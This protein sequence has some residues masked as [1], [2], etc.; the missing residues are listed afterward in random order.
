[1]RIIAGRG[2][3]GKSTIIYDEI[4]NYIKANPLSTCILIVPD[5]ITFQAEN[6]MIARINNDGIMD[7]SILSIGGLVNKI[8]E[9]Q[10]KVNISE[11]TTFGKLLLLKKIIKNNEHRLNFYNK[12]IDTQGMLYELESVIKEFKKNEISPE[13]LKEIVLNTDRVVTGKKL[14]DIQLIYDDYI[15]ATRDIYYDSEDKL[16]YATK[17]I[18]DSKWIKNSKV[19]ID[20]YDHFDR[21]EISLIVALNQVSRG[22]SLSLNIDPTYLSN[23]EDKEDWEAFKIIH[24]TYHSFSNIMNEDEAIIE[25]SYTKGIADEVRRIEENIYSVEP[26][27]FEDEVK[28]VRVYGSLNPYEEVERAAGIIKRLVR[29]KGYRYKDFKL[30]VSD[31][32]LYSNEFKKIFDMEDIPYYIDENKDVL[33][34]ST[35][36]LIVSI[37]DMFSGNFRSEDVVKYL[38]SGYSKLNP[39]QIN[40]LE[41]AALQ[42]GLKGDGWFENIGFNVEEDILEAH[43]IFKSYFSNEREEYKRLS[44]IGDY[45]IFILKFL[46]NLQVK[47]QIK[48]KYDEYIMG[49]NYVK[50]SELSQSWNSIMEVLEQ[51]LIISEEERITI[52]SYK[53]LLETGLKEIKIRTIPPIIDSIEVGD[54]RNISVK[55]TKVLI[56]IG[57]TQEVVSDN[58]EKGLLTDDDRKVIINWGYSLQNGT[59]FNTFRSNHI[60]YRLFNVPSEELYISYPL[61]SNDNSTNQPALILNNLR[62]IYP[63]AFDDRILNDDLHLVEGVSRS[64]EHL[65]IFLRNYIE[66]EDISP[67][68]KEVYRWFSKNEVDLTSDLIESLEYSNNG[69]RLDSE[70]ILNRFEHNL[71]MTVTKLEKYSECP[72]KY[73]VEDI[74]RPKERIIQKVEFYDIGN[75]HHDVIEDYINSI[76]KDEDL[77]IKLTRDDARAL[78]K[79][80]IE[81]IRKMENLRNLAF[82]STKRN[83][84]IQRKMERVLLSSSE[85]IL[86]QIQSGEFRPRFSELNIGMGKGDKIKLDPY[87]ITLDKGTI[88]LRGKIDRVDTYKDEVG[89]EY[90]RIV[91]YKSSKKRI[92]LKDLYEGLQLQLFVYL[93]AMVDRGAS[94]LGSK[95]KVGG[96]YYFAVDDPI[97][98]QEVGDPYEAKLKELR[99]SGY[100]LNDSRIIKAMDLDYENSN[101][102][103]VR[104]TKAGLPYSGS[105][106]LDEEQFGILLDFVQDKV[107][108]ISSGI[109]NGDFPILPYKKNRN[110]DAC[111]YCDYK[112]ICMFDTTN[113]DMYRNIKGVTNKPAEFIHLIKSKGGSSDNGMD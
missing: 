59:E 45:S 22:L 97:F 24:D 57:L 8:L 37:L 60:L 40:K 86:F 56:I 32:R 27:T 74:L 25:S 58:K 108:E 46:T 41:N 83:K 65:A 55:G 7:V 67:S 10:G 53:Q 17:L 107:K 85:V 99:L 105:P 12:V 16:Y 36:K 33:N 100:T 49:N 51:L 69:E 21:A 23:I 71:N 5:I 79:E 96:L 88:K 94:I 30:A 6:H 42:F 98:D 66:T 29:T 106:L 48:E 75:E 35:V 76:M 31:S 82:E 14:A 81:K 43:N 50:A 109:I 19:W 103:S 63:R 44:S 70:T 73:F 9:E 13:G 72:F 54:L 101:V 61:S 2:K 62:K 92:E 4:D 39:H 93:L 84:Y 77:L 91:D 11:I 15:K 34:S 113:D 102:L 52:S 1:M 20:G 18:N 104:F 80:S 89:E 26:S 112:S 68:W 90:I 87:I 95:P 3:T 111:R 78:M 28:N 110:D 38:K 64:R 47:D